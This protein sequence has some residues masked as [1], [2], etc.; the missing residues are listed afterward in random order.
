MYEKV[1][2]VFIGLDEIVVFG[3]VKLFYCFCCYGFFFWLLVV[4][5]FIYCG[6]DRIGWFLINCFLR[7]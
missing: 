4:I 6:C 3:V 1:V 7:L 2:I 5:V